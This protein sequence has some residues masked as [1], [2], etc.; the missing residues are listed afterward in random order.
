VHLV[1]EDLF[2]EGH[3][4][5]VAPGRSPRSRKS[6]GEYTNFGCAVAHGFWML[7]GARSAPLSGLSVDCSSRC[8]GLFF[9]SR[10]TS[11]LLRSAVRQGNPSLAVACA[12]GSHCAPFD[13]P[14]R[15]F[16][17]GYREKG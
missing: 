10:V 1:K 4:V 15:R 8:E 16:W 13:R 7:E 11:A 6:I 3:A 12:R 14:A 5:I 17:E 2:F 9:L